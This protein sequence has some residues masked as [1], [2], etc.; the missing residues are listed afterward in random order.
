[1][2]LIVSYDWPVTFSFRC[3]CGFTTKPAATLEWAGRQADVHMAEKFPIGTQRRPCRI[4]DRKQTTGMEPAK[5]F[6][7]GRKILEDR[8]K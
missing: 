5:A 8:K 2:K 3:A 1:M 6:E 4:S 7:A